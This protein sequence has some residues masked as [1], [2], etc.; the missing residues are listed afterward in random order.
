MEQHDLF[1]NNSVE[2]V[3]LEARDPIDEVM[4]QLDD[5]LRISFIRSF[6]YSLTS[7]IFK[8]MRHSGLKDSAV[9]VLR[10]LLRITSRAYP[11]DASISQ[12]FSPN[13]E[14][15]AYFIALLPVST[16]RKTYKILLDD[17][18]VD[19]TSLEAIS[20]S[21]EADES[22]PRINAAVLGIEDSQQALL[23]T[24]FMGTML[25]TAQGNDAET[26]ILYGLLSSLAVSYPDTVT[27][28]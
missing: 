2:N 6:S 20:D 23:A 10:S 16:T 24:S 1:K 28:M 5:I 13:P 19:D 8:G 27:M 26:E 11:A 15:V 21:A 7:I 14:A 25:T 4:S 3:L 22:T 12:R 18:N 9:S 17:A